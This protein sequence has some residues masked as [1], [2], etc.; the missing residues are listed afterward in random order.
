MAEILS[1]Q[2]IFSL[3][4]G[5]AS[6]QVRT[7]SEGDE[8]GDKIVERFD[9]RLPQRI[10]E[11]HLRIIRAIHENFADSFKTYLV[12]RLQM[13]VSVTLQSVE[14]MQY[15]EYV[16]GNI[17]PRSLYVFRVE[18]SSTYAIFELTPELI[19][20]LVERLLGGSLADAIAQGSQEPRAITKIEQ[21]IV[22]G[23]IQRG[24]TDLQNAWR[25]LAPLTFRLER[26]E[27]RGD[28]AQI[29]PSNEIVLV[30]VF[31]IAIADK[32]FGLNVCFPTAAVKDVLEKLEGQEKIQLR[33]SKGR[34]SWTGELTRK[35]EM[36][37]LPMTIRL[38][39]VK[40]PI[41]DL[42]HMEVG[43]VLRLDTKITDEVSILIGGKQK[44]FGKPGTS[45]GN[46]AVKVTR[47]IS[48]DQLRGEN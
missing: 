5:I 45:N 22:K 6:G 40:L 25:R 43:D 26:Y 44:F 10:S 39:Q 9:F 36:T 7:Q 2:E 37:E 42:L 3:L 12:S 33:A 38:G 48:E 29:T 14:Q 15:N 31:D 24:L 27:S 35:I 19:L 47:P 41:Q 4:G 16:F 20:A 21:S 28:F 30:L 11:D 34:D 13:M 1:K 32:H 8:N 17:G 18:E 23:F 46:I